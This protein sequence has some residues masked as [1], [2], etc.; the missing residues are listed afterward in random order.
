MLPLERGFVR[1]L[2]QTLQRVSETAGMRWSEL[3]DDAKIWT[4]PRERAKNGRGHVV[5]LPPA[6]QAELRAIPRV[7]GCS[8]VFSGA[9]GA[10]TTFGNIKRKLSLA[11]RAEQIQAD[12]D[13]AEW[14]NW[15]F[16]DARRSGV[17]ALA[18]MGFAPH[19]CDRLLNHLTGTIS[20]VAAVYQRHEFHKERAVAL[21]AWA[22]HITAC[23]QQEPTPRISSGSPAR[24]ED[25]ATLPPSNP[26]AGRP[27]ADPLV[28]R[29]VVAN[30]SPHRAARDWRHRGRGA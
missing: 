17:S 29:R 21:A 9:S 14:P 18:R 7:V 11:V 24:A 27:A 25:G 16:H 4:V 10:I 6:P 26:G 2:L 13:A 1:L 22:A 23:A 15:R 19:V 20:G 12:P 30:L 28:G 5:H 8:F 3:S